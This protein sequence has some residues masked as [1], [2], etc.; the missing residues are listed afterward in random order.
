[1]LS[2][3]LKSASGAGAFIRAFLFD[4]AR[5]GSG[6]YVRDT[7]LARRR[8][9]EHGC[10]A[11]SD[12]RGWLSR[13]RPSV[14]CRSRFVRRGAPAYPDQAPP[15]TSGKM[16]IEAPAREADLPPQAGSLTCQPSLKNPRSFLGDALNGLWQRRRAVVV[17]PAFVKVGPMK[18]QQQAERIKGCFAH[19]RMLRRAAASMSTNYRVALLRLAAR[20]ES[21]AKR[22]TSRPEWIEPPPSSN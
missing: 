20:W 9:V 12:P 1:M 16:R 22:P 17:M 4:V 15:S 7:P 18:R 5:S 19:A 10:T 21:L 2:P 13:D 6:R 3:G 14:L 11:P 8:R